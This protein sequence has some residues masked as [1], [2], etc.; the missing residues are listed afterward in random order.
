MPCSKGTV[1]AL[2]QGI[3]PKKYRQQAVTK[4]ILRLLNG[5]ATPEEVNSMFE[6]AAEQNSE[7]K[8]FKASTLLSKYSFTQV[9]ANK[10]LKE[11]GIKLSLSGFNMFLNNGYT[12]NAYTLK[13]IQQPLEAWLAAVATKEEI[14]TMW[15]TTAKEHKATTKK[16]LFNNNFVETLEPE[17][18]TN[19]AMK[20]FRVAQHPFADEMRG[21]GDLYMSNHHMRVREAM[22]QAANNGSI[23]AVA[24]ECGAGKSTLRECFNEYT[25]IEMPDLVIIEPEVTDKKLLTAAMI[26]EAI[27]DELDIKKLSV[28]HEKRSR[29]IKRELI[30]SVKSGNKHVIVIEEAHDLTNQVLKHLKRVHE[31]RDGFRPL[32]GIILVGQVELNGNLNNYDV[33]EFSLRCNV[34]D[35]PPLGLSITEYVAHKFSRKG[36][37]HTKVITQCGIDAIKERLQG[38][39]SFG[40]KRSQ[41]SKDMS[42]PLNVNTMLVKA[43]NLASS[44]SEPLIT[45]EIINK[46]K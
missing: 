24:A 32:L 25:K 31:L 13:D 40:L 19:K 36:V 8:T 30:K 2:M 9:D 38:T 39:T 35:L 20:H 42:Y 18:L 15:Q 4:S 11:A 17:M 5:R 41:E 37:D 46:I 23:L 27:A 45:Q 7:P 16:N 22:I 12:P 6:N 26:F 43:M 14:K 10:V 29:Q 28:G 34:V 44:M 33:R 1:R 3:W 21:M